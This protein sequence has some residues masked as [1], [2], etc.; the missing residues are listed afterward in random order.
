MREASIA[1]FKGAA[2]FTVS[3]S[4]RLLG[5]TAVNRARSYFR[6]PK[7]EIRE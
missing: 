1:P 7:A 3:L 6:L 5:T 2:L 4:K